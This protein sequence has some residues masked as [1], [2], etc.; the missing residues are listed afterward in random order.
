VKTPVGHTST[1]FPANSLSQHTVTVAAEENDISQRKCV[2]VCSS[3]V[4]TIETHTAIALDA[5]VHLVVH[6]GTQVLVSKRAFFERVAA[7]IM[8]RHYGHVLQVALAAFIAH[9][10]I[11]GVVQHQAFNN[12][13][14]EFGR[15]RVL[16]RDAG[17]FDGGRHT[18]H[19]DLA[20]RIA[21][22][23]ELLDR[24]LAAGTHRT[25]RGVPAEIRQV[26]AQ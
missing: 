18:G 9:R 11:V 2:Q 14:P 24:A 5:A 4:L 10:A 1:R 8:T 26:H 6:E 19:H 21:R 12:G 20:A 22:I 13:R 16:N 25:H 15:L 7:I 3:G 23:F 17:A